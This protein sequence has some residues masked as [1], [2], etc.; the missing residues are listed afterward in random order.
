[1]VESLNVNGPQL[2]LVFAMTGVQATLLLY[3]LINFNTFIEFCKGTNQSGKYGKVKNILL[4]LFYSY[5]PLTIVSV[6]FMW[7]SYA[8]DWAAGYGFVFPPYLSIIFFLF[9]LMITK[10]DVSNFVDVQRNARARLPAQSIP[11]PL[12]VGEV[13]AS[14]YNDTQGGGTMLV[15]ETNIPALPLA[16]ADDAFEP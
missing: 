14:A 9:V 8:Q 6:A 7:I 4:I 13:K 11:F 10:N 15:E 16:D 2:W 3:Q 1:M 12:Q 5:V